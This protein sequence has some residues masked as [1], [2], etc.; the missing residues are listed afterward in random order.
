MERD[1][2]MIAMRGRPP[3]ELDG[4][5][6]VPLDGWWGDASLD[7]PRIAYERF[8]DTCRLW[9]GETKKRDG[10]IFKYFGYDAGR[11]TECMWV[12]NFANFL[13]SAKYQKLMPYWSVMC[14]IL[15]MMY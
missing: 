1:Q 9:V 5:E 12:K 15:C 6:D 8:I 11:T 10:R 14:V 7:D 4:L 3:C 2:A 13:R